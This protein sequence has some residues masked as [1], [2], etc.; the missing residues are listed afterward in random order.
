MSNK[1]EHMLL[2]GLACFGGYILIKRMLNEEVNFG[3]ALCCGIVGAG[4]ARLPDIIEPAINPSHRAIAH[5]LATSGALIYTTKKVLETQRFDSDQK[6]AITG[7]IAAY[8]SHLAA[9]S[10]TPAGLPL[11]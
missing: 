8:L 4:V 3:N 5:S 10:T 2:G 9:D 7:L 1:G 6:A 11:I